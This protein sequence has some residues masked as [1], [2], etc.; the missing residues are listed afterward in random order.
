MW[1]VKKERIKWRKKER[2]RERELKFW[3]IV[4]NVRERENWNFDIMS[5]YV[6]HEIINQTFTRWSSLRNRSTLLSHLYSNGEK[7]A[8]TKRFCAEFA[9]SVISDIE[10]MT[11]RKKG[12]GRVK[13][14]LSVYD[15][16]IILEFFFPLQ[17]THQRLTQH[18]SY[19]W[20][21]L[22]LYTN[23][24]TYKYTHTHILYL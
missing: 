5:K 19:F 20:F 17:P 12:E 23:T 24:Y 11:V 16:M 1:K 3:Y 22:S 8:W 15:R 21:L 4:R 2:K 14:C 10:E 9:N 6:K 18:L 7:I 13:S